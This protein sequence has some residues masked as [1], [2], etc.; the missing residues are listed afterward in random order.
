MDIGSILLGLALLLVVAFYVARP[1][2]DQSGAAEREPG[3]A[4]QLLF[5]RE[6]VLTALRDLDFDHAMG[7]TVEDDYTTQR[8]QLLA[9]GAEVL[10]QL[11][12]LGL[13]PASDSAGLDD[14]IERAVARRRAS[15]AVAPAPGAAPV[16]DEIEA[17]IA[18]RRT[19]PSA[20]RFCAQ[21]GRQALPDDKFCGA[22]GAPLTVVSPRRREEHE[23]HQG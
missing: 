11:D 15:A 21:C 7:K 8:E 14:E 13:P 18:A 22:C 16:D 19:A 17:S 3:P 12:A 1:L 9:H 10:K 20:A 4:D 6:R 2:L 5:E 23:G